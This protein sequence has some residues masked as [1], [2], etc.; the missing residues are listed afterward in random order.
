MK[1]LVN[2]TA[3][4]LQGIVGLGMGKANGIG[5]AIKK[6]NRQASPTCQFGANFTTLRS[7]LSC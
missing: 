6:A 5:D 3:N 7:A 1:A 2:I 4:S